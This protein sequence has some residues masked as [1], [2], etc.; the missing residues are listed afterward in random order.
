MISLYQIANILLF[1]NIAGLLSSCK[2]NSKIEIKTYKLTFYDNQ[3]QETK[4]KLDKIES[5]DS[6]Y[7]YL[8]NENIF[9]KI[10]QI[11]QYVTTTQIIQ[12]RKSTYDILDTYRWT[13]SLPDSITQ[14][15]LNPIRIGKEPLSDWKSYFVNKYRGDLDSLNK[16]EG[17]NRTMVA[18]HLLS[19]ISQWYHF[20][21]KILPLRYPSLEDLLLY[22]KGDCYR[23]AYLNTLCLRACGIPSSVD[24]T[25]FWGNNKGGGHTETSIFGDNNSFEI[26]LNAKH[27]D[28]FKN[29]PKVYRVMDECKDFAWLV[30]MKLHPDVSFLRDLSYKDVTSEYTNT[31]SLTIP[32]HPNM[33]KKN[34]LAYLCVLN[35]NKWRPVAVSAIEKDKVCFKHV[36]KGN[37][38]K[39]ATV[40]EADNL[41]FLDTTIKI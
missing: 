9:F 25:P 24:F 40:N 34:N 8:A 29:V 31:Q 30:P 39:V 6:L 2:K 1:L 3:Q 26:D 36:G 28:S 35:A 19:K 22:H 27:K 5:I 13:N 15:Y 41:I 16:I 14:Q 12:N 7:S 38:Y 20:D 23:I 17:I 32:I 11:S 18:S 37:E 33:I 21:E 4:L 10:D